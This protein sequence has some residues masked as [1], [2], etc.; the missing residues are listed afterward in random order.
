MEWKQAPRIIFPFF[1]LMTLCSLLAVRASELRGRWEHRVGRLPHGHMV[2]LEK[3][4]E[5]GKRESLGKKVHLTREDKLQRIPPKLFI[6][7][8]V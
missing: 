6:Q 8:L 7:T 3:C 4:L 2:V 1:E 5:G